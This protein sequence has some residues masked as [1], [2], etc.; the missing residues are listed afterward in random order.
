MFATKRDF[1]ATLFTATTVVMTI[2]PCAVAQ[3]ASAL[4]TVK[5][6]EGKTV[7]VATD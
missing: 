2:S 6:V 4:G 5:S 7:T 1:L 3:N